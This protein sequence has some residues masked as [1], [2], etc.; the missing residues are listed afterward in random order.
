[1]LAEWI[2]DVVGLDEIW[3]IP[4]GSPY[5]KARESILPGRERLRMAELAIEGNPFFRCLDWEVKRKGDT[6]SYETLEQLRESYP[7]DLFY[8]IVGAD[9]LFTI[10]TWKKPERIFANCTLV[11]AV[12]GDVS[13][14]AMEARKAELVRKFQTPEKNVEIMLVPFIQ[15][16]LSSTQ[17]RQRIRQGQSIR[18]LVPDQVVTYIE[19][20]GYY[21]EKRDTFEET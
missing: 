13:M 18:Y 12:R 1:M 5:L 15:L 17:I 7:Q 9:C 3:F 8:F 11:A 21:R 20:R 2:R 10:D 14:E 4:T 6:Y 16:S 19:G